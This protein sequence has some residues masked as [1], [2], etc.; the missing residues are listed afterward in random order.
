MQPAVYTNAKKNDTMPDLTN[1]VTTSEAAQELGFHVNHIRRMV[2]R[3]DLKTMRVGQMIFISS[4][5]IKV[6]KDKTK[7]FDKHSPLKR[8]NL[9]TK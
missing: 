7:G 5:S 2:R 4:E 6:Y 1:F 3:G 8:E 9:N